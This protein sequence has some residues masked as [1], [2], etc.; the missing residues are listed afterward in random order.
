MPLTNAPIE[1]RARFLAALS[2][3]GAAAIL[4]TAG[5]KVRN[6]DSEYRFRPDSDFWYL[7]GFAE[8]DSV[9]VLLPGNAS[10]PAHRA[11]LFLREKKR[12]EEIWNGLRLGLEAAPATLGIDAA[13]PIAELWTRLPELLKGYE[14]IV[15]RSGLDETRDRA[16]HACLAKLRAQVR[17]NFALPSEVIDP[18]PLLHE[19]R[20]FKTPAELA[21]M[22]KAAAI[23]AE[24]HIAAMRETRAGQRENEIDAL[25][26]YTFLRRGASGA[27]YGNIVA[28]GANACILHYVENNRELRDGD[29]LLIDAGAEFDC[30]ASDV[31][32]TFPVNGRFSAEQRALYEVVLE[33]QLAAIAQVAPGNSFLSV[34]EVALRVLCEGFARLGLLPGSADEIVKN[35]SYKRF[36]MHRTSHWL[37]LD[38]HDCGAYVIGGKSRA[39]EAGQVLTVEPGAYIA[40]DDESVEARWRGIGI[41]IEDDLLVTSTGHEVLTREIPKTIE[42]IER[43]CSR[44]TPAATTSR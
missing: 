15:Y 17:A 8:P 44:Q 39:L 6:H 23:S 26:T 2:E 19:Q 38:V 5:A 30:Y 14:R 31:T 36:Y 42:A 20:L 1:N 12:D 22:R 4:P 16:V 13:F 35:E 25:L 21:L 7:T 32:R 37:G 24:A 10:A 28:G 41:R 43:T 3:R 33:S 34:H 27:A 40:P 18:A 11:V 29:L 9:L